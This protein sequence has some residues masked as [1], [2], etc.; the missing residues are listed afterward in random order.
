MK[1]KWDIRHRTR[2]EYASAVRDSFN[3]IRLKP[4]SNEHQRLETFDL[5][6]QPP[7]RVGHYADF[8]AN[9]VSHFDITD[10]HTSLEVETRST[11]VTHPLKPLGR[12]ARP[13]PLN[14]LREVIFKENCFDYTQTSRFID[15]GPAIWRLAIDATQG[16]SDAWQAALALMR[17]ANSYLTYTPQA[18]SVHTHVRD[19]IELRRGVCQDFA[20]LTIAL[21]RSLHIPALYVSGYL[22]T[23]TASATHAWMEVFVP[24]V[25]WCALDPTHNCQPGENYI[26]LAV[27]RD[28]NDVP[29]VRGTYRGTAARRMEVDVKIRALD[30]WVPA[31]G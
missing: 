16:H 29:P 10:P 23:E 9:W 18:T 8:Y 2:F 4:I 11:V 6:V 3:E 14:S 12:D 22:A 20:H 28:Y 31:A 7:A 1:M 15:A 24:G 27:G 17:F 26:K 13:A 5:T 21:C 30:D 25:G 19:L